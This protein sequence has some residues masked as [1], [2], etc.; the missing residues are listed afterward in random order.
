MEEPTMNKAFTGRGLV[1][2]PLL[3]GLVLLLL[4][5]RAAAASETTFTFTDR[6]ITVSGGGAG[7]EVDGTDLSITAAGTYTITGSC[8]EG[9]ITVKKEVT[10]VTLILDDLTLASSQTSP[11]TCNKSSEVTVQVTG[12]N[13]LADKEDLADDGVSATFEGA[14]IKVKTGASLTLTGTGT[15]TVNGDC[16]NGIKGAA[17]ASVTVDG[18]TLVVTAQN[19]ALS[20]DHAVTIASG[21]LTLTAQGAGVKASPDAGDSDSQG[22]VEIT[23]GTL[24]I[25]ATDDGIHGVSVTLAGGTYD[26]Q[27]GDDGVHADYDLVL[28]VK[29][30][31]TGPNV[32]ISDAV[33][34]L[35]GASVTLYAG[36]GTI[37]A[38]DDGINA[39]NSDLTSY[40]FDITVY[41]GDWMV[42]AGGD[43]L[44]SNQ[45]IFL[46]GGVVEVY[47]SANGGDA[48]LDYDG[49]CTAQGGTLLAV[50]MGQMAQVPSTGTYV[51]FGTTG[52]MGGGGMGG[53][54]RPDDMGTPP[55]MAGQTEGFPGRGDRQDGTRGQQG[56][57]PTDE[58][59]TGQQGTPPDMDGQTLPKGFSGGG[60]MGGMME[61][62]AVSIV[63]GSVITIQDSGGGT[64]YTATGV[65]N[66]NSVVFVSGDLTEGDSYTLLVDGAEGE[67]SQAQAGTGA[68][69]GFGGH[70][71]QT[72]Q[73]GQTGGEGFALPF[74]DITGSDWYFSAV[75]FVQEKGLM[76]GVSSD[77]FDPDGGLTRAM[78]AQILYRVAGSPTVTATDSFSDVADGAWYHDSVTWAAENQ[79]VQGYGDGTFG[80]EDPV[81]REQMAVFLYRY[82]MGQGYDTATA[83]LSA[84][85]DL[86]QVSS[87]ALDALGW[88]NGAEIIT[89]T[90]PNVLAP[91]S[92]ATRAQT[93]TILMRFVQAYQ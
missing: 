59:P 25:R 67:T 6:A 47:G 20:S 92:G 77:S 30:S 38:S 19:D 35:E 46:Y 18:P 39:A 81:T 44:D 69:G 16:K 90:D 52:M 50:G 57:M 5:G 85:Q 62:S 64:L 60:N 55:D 28:G 13:T 36:S 86:S 74:R 40:E 70:G 31:Q 51:A 29:D 42:N 45:D 3:L 76:S 72:G 53:G 33:E 75:S 26:I 79:L 93:A 41:G 80:P 73:T 21:N 65:K 68:T 49:T 1:L 22:K 2:L 54:Q 87:Y 61:A 8:A 11:L 15:L 71:G 9:T 43:G 82:A 37:N 48:A 10:G 14:G 84:Y 34:G 4:P 83:D 17:Q 66:A 24:T 78:L 12:E 88:A 56:Q 27:S 23:G 7:Y 91:Q 63:Q 58:M 89:G 32:T